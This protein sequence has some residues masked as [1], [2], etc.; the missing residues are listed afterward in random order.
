[1]EEEWAVTGEEWSPGHKAAVVPGAR[2][3]HRRAVHRFLCAAVRPALAA[4]LPRV[5][6]VDLPDE[7]LERGVGPAGADGLGLRPPSPPGSRKNCPV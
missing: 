2:A 4:R 3:H 1:M 7:P 5:P 6:D